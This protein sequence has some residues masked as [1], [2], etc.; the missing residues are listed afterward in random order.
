M[1]SLLAR[2]EN[3][4]KRRNLKRNMVEY[5]LIISTVSLAAIAYLIS[6]GEKIAQTYQ[7][8]SNALH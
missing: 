7:Q 1:K 4:I 6:L 5:S 8:I 2:V 3:F